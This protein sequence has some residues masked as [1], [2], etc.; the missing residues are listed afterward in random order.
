MS[1]DMH[2]DTMGEALDD[3]AFA[4]LVT[5]L[6]DVAEQ[7]APPVGPELMAVLAGDFPDGVAPLAAARA[8]RRRSA[9]AVLISVVS[10]GVLAGGISAAAAD[11]LPAP[12]QRVVARVVNT[13]TPFE[14][15]DRGLREH[16]DRDSDERSVP[17]DPAEPEVHVTVPREVA[18]PAPT[19][20][21]APDTTPTD[22]TSGTQED[23]RGDEDSAEQAEEETNGA[24][25]EI[26]EPREGS[27]EATE[28]PREESGEGDGD[29]D[30]RSGEDG[31]GGEDR[32]GRDR[33]ED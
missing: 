30:D 19:P 31:D 24:G 22:A 23:S 7:P 14:I 6:R 1:T 27:G 9:S 10:T 11:E 2:E 29:D 18:P 20:P 21:T 13:I 12:M 26:E 33:S 4:G 15:P 16:R 5:K 25:E 3:P 32:D 17:P 8:R 28:E